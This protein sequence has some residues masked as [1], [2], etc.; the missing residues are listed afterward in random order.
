MVDAEQTQPRG[1]VQHRLG[2]SLS[3]SSLPKTA[4][5][6]DLKSWTTS[7]AH[8]VSRIDFPSISI[9]SQR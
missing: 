1:G 2:L 8:V 6:P 4:V 7:T 5:F 9:Q 3:L